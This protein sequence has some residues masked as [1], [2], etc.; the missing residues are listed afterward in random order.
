MNISSHTF[1]PLSF[2]L[3]VYYND[4]MQPVTTQYGYSSLSP[5]RGG[6]LLNYNFIENNRSFSPV[7]RIS[8]QTFDSILHVAT[9]QRPTSVFFFNHVM[10]N[11]F[12]PFVQSLTF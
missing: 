10:R 11:P 12:N 3:S 5:N 2:Q 9:F 1:P 4:N 6:N 7:Q 8:N